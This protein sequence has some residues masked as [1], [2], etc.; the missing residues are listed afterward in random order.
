VIKRIVYDKAAAMEEAGRA[1]QWPEWFMFR[2]KGVLLGTSVA[3]TRAVDLNLSC[4]ERNSSR[5]DNC[6]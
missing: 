6:G 2:T 4:R 3:R 5:A 1:M